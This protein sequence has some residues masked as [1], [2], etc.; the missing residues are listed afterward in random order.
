M[1]M[2]NPTTAA[3]RVPLLCDEHQ[4]PLTEALASVEARFLAAYLASPA[5]REALAA[6]LPSV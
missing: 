5:F 1:A 2:T 6:A 3:G 4:R